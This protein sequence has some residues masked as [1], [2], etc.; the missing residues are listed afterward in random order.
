MYLNLVID[1]SLSWAEIVE[2]CTVIFATFDSDIFGK[3]YVHSDT[4]RYIKYI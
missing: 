4:L 2:C 1:G 3:K